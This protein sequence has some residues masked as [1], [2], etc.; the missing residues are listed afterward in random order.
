MG[1]LGI[2]LMASLPGYHDNMCRSATTMIGNHLPGGAIA[3]L[4]FV[5][6][7]WNGLLGRINRKLALSSKEMAVVLV[8]TLVACFPPTAGFFRY[9]FRIVMLPWYYLPGH[10]EWAEHNLLGSLNPKLF[11]EPYLGNGVPTPGTEAY[12]TY[13][14]VYQGFFS[15]LAKGTHWLSFSELPIGAWVRPMMYWGPLVLLVSLAC[16]SMQFVVHRQWSRHEQLSYPLA[17]VTGAFCLRKDGLPGVPDLFRQRLFWVGFAPVFLLYFLE[18]LGAKYPTLFPST[19]QFFPNLRSWGLPILNTF[20]VLNHATGKWALNG[21]SLFFTIV[22]VAYFVSTEISLTVGLSQIALALFTTLIYT[23]FGTPVSGIQVELSRA[24]S[25]L[26]YTLILLYTGRTWFRA[27]YARAFGLYRRRS[28]VADDD[29]AA[30]LAARVLVLSFVGILAVL[31]CMGFEF[32]LALLFTVLTLMLFFVFTRI[33]CETGIPYLQAGWFPPNLLVYLFGQAA[34]GPGSLM[35][36][37]WVNVVLLQD[38]REC[39]MPYV[40]TGMKVADDAGLR[41]RR[42]FWIVVAAVVLAIGVAFT[43]SM[44][45]HYNAGAMTDG[46]SSG[47]AVVNPFNACS[48]LVREMKNV[49]EYEIAAKASVV[50]RLSLIRVQPEN[51]QYFLLGLAMVV[52]CSVMRFK[53]AKFPLHPVLFMVWGTTPIERTWG[54]FLVGWFLKVLVVRFGGGG[55]YRRWKPLFVG[56]IA[57]ELVFVGVQVAYGLLYVLFVGTP[58]TFGVRALPT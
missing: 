32:T 22:G 14:T 19:D 6:L 24:G 9:F 52:F 2:V 1:L 20:P 17:Q 57:G 54:S 28:S 5:G 37:Y 43:V 56:L 23:L 18:F 42:T 26:G 58:P 51:M 55:V 47:G 48:R 53:F 39:L 44:Y 50:E 46:W 3:Y 33:V 25:Y 12:G 30:V 10:P 45:T 49:G 21:Q 7:V 38:P 36:L 13:Q 15:G 29:P 8:A 11:P 31:V 40:A 27:V 34:V 4:F 41:M 35:L 16:I